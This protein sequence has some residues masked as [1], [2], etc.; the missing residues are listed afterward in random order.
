MRIDS[1]HDI[2][3]ITVKNYA[4][5]GKKRAPDVDSQNNR[6]QLHNGDMK[7]FPAVRKRTSDPVAT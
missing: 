5:V 4:F 6:I 1:T 2:T 7:A 3:V